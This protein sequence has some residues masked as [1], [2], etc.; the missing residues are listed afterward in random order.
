MPRRKN[1]ETT[2][3]PQSEQPMTSSE[4]AATITFTGDPRDRTGDGDP[5]IAEYGGK[6][7]PKGKA[8][9]V[10]ADWLRL[11]PN[12]LKNNHFKVE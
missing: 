6:S 11:N 8:V 2:E 7:F 4:Q 5:K 1:V 12:I 9:S 10:D 3:M